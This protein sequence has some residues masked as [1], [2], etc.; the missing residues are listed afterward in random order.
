MSK[1]AVGLFENP[2]GAEQVVRDLE[3]SA[4]PRNEIRILREPL[5]MA[6]AGVAS[7][8]HT[9]FEVSLGRD[10]GASEGEANA[11]VQAVRR[12]GVLVFATGSNE[13][14]DHAAEIMN[15][16]GAIRVEELVGR[17][18]SGMGA[19]GGSLPLSRDENMPVRDTT[20]TGRVRQ[21]GDGARMFVW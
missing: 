1:T 21:S 17:E 18:P 4:F 15:R 9:D 5:D 10:I 3:A 13:G 16:H 20:Q 7:I 14:M 2:G 8:P 6:V 12:G 11:Y 19:M